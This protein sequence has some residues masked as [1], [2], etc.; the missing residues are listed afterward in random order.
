MDE[1]WQRAT[2]AGVV[3]LI[4]LVVAKL[5]DRTLARRLERRPETLT[6]YRVVRRS[7][8]AT[9]VAVGVLSALLVIPG[10]RTV[11]GTILASSAVLALV[12]GFAAQS[13]LSNFVS[14]LFIAFAQ[15]LRIG[16]HV[17]VGAAVGAVEE[18][19][20]SYTVIR[21]EDGGRFFIPNA[22]LASDTI[23]NATL[24]SFEHLARV[25]VSVP[26][27]ADL[28]RV[29]ELLV[30]EARAAREAMPEKEPIATVSNLEASSAVVTIDAW[31][32]TAAD[33]GRLAAAIRDAAQRRLRAE[34]VFA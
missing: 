34:G 33:A 1:V 13:T 8:V 25:S 21:A 5:V 22:K 26:I 20:I 6:R 2:A 9:I 10:V 29:R 11:A 14:G 28:D 16:D 23:R 19:G 4:T 17:E 27:T 12:I 24:S 31:A 7:A 18:I 3:I 15:P 30:A 32:R